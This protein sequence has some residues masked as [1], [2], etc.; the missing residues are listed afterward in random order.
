MWPHQTEQMLVHAHDPRQDRAAPQ[1][2]HRGTG[3]CGLVGAGRD[4]GDLS[5]LDLDVAISLRRG[6][7]AVDHVD[8]L[9]DHARSVYLEIALHLRNGQQQERDAQL[10][11]RAL[12]SGAAIGA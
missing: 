6:T 2:E 12:T 9:E 3:L 7:R 11:G 1:F 8:V 4:A 5:A 10:H